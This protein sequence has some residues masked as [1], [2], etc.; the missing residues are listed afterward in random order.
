MHK[1]TYREFLSMAEQGNLIPVYRDYDGD[2]QTPVDVYERL[3][4]TGFSCYFEKVERGEKNGRFSY[5][6]IN[7][8][9]VFISGG[10]EIRGESE[11]GRTSDPFEDLKD[12]TERL[13]PVG[14]NE[15]PDDYPGIIGFFSYDAVRHIE[16]LPDLNHDDLNI[17]DAVMIFPGNVIVFD[18][19][20]RAIRVI[21]NCLLDGI[22]DSNDMKEAYLKAVRNIDGIITTLKSEAGN[23]KLQDKR[24]DKGKSFQPIQF[25][26]NIA[27]E[28]FEKAVVRA[29]EYIEA[30]DAIQIV[31]SRRLEAEIR[32][33]PLRIFKTLKEVNPSPYM[34]FMDFGEVKLI[35]SSPELLV[36]VDGNRVTTNPIAGTRPRFNEPGMDGEME[37]E[38]LADE[39]ERAEHLML[40][41]LSRND[42]GRVSKFG[43]V[44]VKRFME[45]ERFSHVIHLVSEVE[46]ELLENLNCLDALKACF[47]A[48]TVSG[49]PKIRA[50]EVIEE[51]ETNKRGPY[52]GAVVNLNFRGGMDSCIIIRTI[53]MKGNKAYIQ[54]G[55]GIVTDS[56]PEREYE[57]T[58]KKAEALIRAVKL[59]EEVEG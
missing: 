46:G 25:K 51:L 44:N 50:M 57:E 34:F 11:K 8:V 27:R 1:P 21:S 20:L 18:N 30:G 47:P 56:I 24:K 48:G 7:P 43:S 29:K 9:K 52:A 23:G 41:D 54:A 40:V 49:A 10:N 31:I 14:Y 19:H 35:G 4:G 26:T 16:S 5:I 15:L 36:K 58:Q 37:K 38:L 17:P 12:V 45:V 42:L 55:A 22:S 28:D 33:D 59:A 39:K 6:C 32:I 2:Y 13:K 3:K 53:V